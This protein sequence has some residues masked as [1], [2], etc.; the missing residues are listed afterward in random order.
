MFYLRDLE[1]RGHVSSGREVVC[2]P[3]SAPP[4]PVRLDRVALCRMGDA[5]V[6]ALGAE[7]CIIPTRDENIDDVRARIALHLFGN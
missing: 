7:F 6:F 1:G 4:P 5:E 2:A 3:P